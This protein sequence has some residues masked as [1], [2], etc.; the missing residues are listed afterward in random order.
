MICNQAVFCEYVGSAEVLHMAL[1][2]E[3]V[4][5]ASFRRSRRPAASRTILAVRVLLLT[6]AVAAFASHALFLC[7]YPR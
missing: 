7:V 3:D 4:G 1:K 2:E 5:D 6:L